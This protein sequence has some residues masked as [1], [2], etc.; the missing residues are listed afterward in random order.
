MHWPL[1]EMKK[2]TFRRR[3]VMKYLNKSKTKNNLFYS[4]PSRRSRNSPH[5]T[6][7]PQQPS[8]SLGHHTLC[9]RHYRWSS[10]PAAAAGVLPLLLSGRLHCHHGYCFF[11]ADCRC[12]RWLKAGCGFPMWMRAQVVSVGVDL[13]F[14][15]YLLHSLLQLRAVES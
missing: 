2:E 14:V 10:Q 9:R 15:P 7:C 3:D 12:A 1:L 13:L 11:F 6:L 8:M 5:L 4:L